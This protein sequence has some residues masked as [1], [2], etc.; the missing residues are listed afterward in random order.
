MAKVK[1][2]YHPSISE[3]EYA[4]YAINEGVAICIHPIPDS[5]TMYWVEKH[6]LDNYKKPTFLRK[7]VSM[8]DSLTNRQVFSEIDAWKKVFE[9]YKLYYDKNNL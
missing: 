6:R 3:L 4:R 7:D 9:M 1:K 2:I 8:K 5:P